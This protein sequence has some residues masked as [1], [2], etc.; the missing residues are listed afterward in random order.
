[1]SDLWDK[2]RWVTFDSMV[3]TVKRSGSAMQ[4]D[5]L[6]T[7]EKWPFTIV[8]AVA[9]PGNERAVQLAKDFNDKMSAIAPTVQADAPGQSA[10]ELRQLNRRQLD[11]LELA[12]GVIANAGGGDWKR[13]SAD[14]QE[15]AAKWRELYH[16]L[17]GVPR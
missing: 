7:P 6:T 11:A 12:W 1:M 2:L 10:A 8:V 13:E 14:W 16:S 4:F 17:L 15:A 5:G 3:T 9:K